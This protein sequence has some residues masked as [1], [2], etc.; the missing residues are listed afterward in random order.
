M[1]KKDV[2]VSISSTRISYDF[3]FHIARKKRRKIQKNDFCPGSY[4]RG[5]LSFDILS[6]ELNN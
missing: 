1:V 2:F 6:I 4:M 5:T 3:P